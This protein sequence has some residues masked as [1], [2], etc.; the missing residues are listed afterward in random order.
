LAV[1]L[2][3]QSKYSANGSKIQA[4]KARIKEYNIHFE[5]LIKKGVENDEKIFNLTKV[6]TESRELKNLKK[7]C[8]FLEKNLA[9]IVEVYR[10]LIEQNKNLKKTVEE[11]QQKLRK[12]D[13]FLEEQNKLIKI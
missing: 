2:Y 11:S 10:S 5:E 13:K 12:K 6:N 1:Y 7:K 8:G 9:E 4:L 3:Y